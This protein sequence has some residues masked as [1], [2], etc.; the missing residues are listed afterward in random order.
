[1]TAEAAENSFKKVKSDML[2]DLAVNIY[3]TLSCSFRKTKVKMEFSVW[4]I[5][6][7][8]PVL[9]AVITIENLKVDS[10]LTTFHEL[11]ACARS[12]ELKYRNQ[13]IG[14]VDGVEHARQLFHAIGIDPTKR[15]PSSEALLNRTLKNKEIHQVNS[16]VDAGN[17]CSLDF[18]LPI[19]VYDSNKIQGQ[20]S[21][22]K[23]YPGEEYMA[24]NNQ[25]MNLA[26]RYVI[27]DEKGAFGSPMTDSQRTAVDENTRAA[28]LV[29]FAPGTYDKNL[30]ITQAQLF[31]QRVL[32]ACGG[33]LK[34]LG[35]FGSQQV[36]NG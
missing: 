6:T 15:R 14:M 32:G 27:A 10:S 19:C 26:D 31:A 4:N 22:R 18:L 3:V 36:I 21:I 5:E 34:H 1:L 28:T 35:T 24:L 13:S 17:W 12:L 29:I 23:G 33:S 9:L 8:L 30:L 2:C 11:L 16:L 25:I 20:V 7:S